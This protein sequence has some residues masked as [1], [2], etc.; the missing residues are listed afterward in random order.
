MRLMI[1][2]K[3]N[4]VWKAIE[5][6]T[7]SRRE[8]LQVGELD[9]AKAM[10]K[11]DKIKMKDEDTVDVLAVEL[12]EVT[13][14]V[15]SLG[16]TIE[17][18]K[19]VRKLLKILTEKIYIR[20]VVSLEQ[21]LELKTTSLEDIIGRPKV[22][23]ERISEEEEEQKDEQGKL[24]N[25]SIDTQENCGG[26]RGRR[27]G[28]RSNWRG[29]S[30][31]R[32]GSYQKGSYKQGR[33]KE[34]DTL[35]IQ[36]CLCDELRLRKFQE[37]TEK[38]DEGIQETNELRIHEVVYLNKRKMMPVSKDAGCQEGIKDA[39]LMIHDRLKQLFVKTTR[40]R[41]C[42]YKVTLE[43]EN[44]SGFFISSIFKQEKNKNMTGGDMMEDDWEF[45]S[46]SNPNRNVVLIGRARNGRSTKDN[47]TLRRKVFKSKYLSRAVTNTS[48]SQRFVRECGQNINIVDTPGLFDLSMT[49]EF[50]AKEIVRCITLAEDGIHAVLFVFTVRGRPT[51]EEKFSLYQ[52]QT[53]FGSKTAVYMITVLTGGNILQDSDET[54]EEYLGQ[55][56]PEFLKEILELCDN[57]MILFNN[58][59]KDKRKKAEQVEKLMSLVDGKPFTDELFHELQEEAIKLGDQ[60]KQVERL[61]GYSKSEL[62][63]K[64]K[65]FKILAEQETR[66]TIITLRT[67]RVGKLVSYEFQAYSDEQR[68]KPNLEVLRVF[69]YINYAK[70]DS[71]GAESWRN[72]GTFILREFS[73]IG[74]RGVKDI[75][76]AEESSQDTRVM[77]ENGT[78]EKLNR[79]EEENNVN[80]D[81][82]EWSQS[83][84]R[85]STRVNVRPAYLDDY[86]LTI[87]TECVY[88][89]L[90]I[91][92]ESWI[93]AC[94]ER[95]LCQKKNL[96]VMVVD[97]LRV[98][99]ALQAEAN[100]YHQ[101]AERKL[102][103]VEKREDDLA[104]R[105]TS[106]KPAV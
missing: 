39:P 57:R 69:N 75:A 47:I 36:C 4:K 26:S 34:R 2:F 94:K 97:D 66:T 22:Y 79:E 24:M 67:D 14:K 100:W 102:K 37:A 8:G 68:K 21:I 17:E 64:F 18:S 58:K 95:P 70:T 63:D 10:A 82:Q 96:L 15:D 85:R 23:K 38:E 42:W 32:S 43:V 101:I 62:L 31:G 7:K 20:N 65:R 59:T 19:F 61:K 87:E 46:S 50:I 56:C 45:A 88:F 98:S 16:E 72:S 92:K 80:G 5:F 52:L 25:A 60:K 40:S 91:N 78:N 106:F 12:S 30:H 27:R 49:A 41:N 29:R 89:L 76:S 73:S 51:D 84:L 28:C 93:E 105:L 77:S 86:A 71:A 83:Q 48:E 81:E 6:G 74:L 33:Y 53:L 55:E 3:E 54:L 44:I 103:E 9:T 99:E 11:F 1:A 90:V 13:S 35:H 104:R